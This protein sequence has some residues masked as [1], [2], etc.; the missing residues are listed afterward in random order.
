M[1]VCVGLTRPPFHKE[2]L[3]ASQR[4]ARKEE[5]VGEALIGAALVALYFAVLSKMWF[6]S[7]LRRG[8]FR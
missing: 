8:R 3:A 6:S 1:H 4:Y 7:S 2:P 5:K